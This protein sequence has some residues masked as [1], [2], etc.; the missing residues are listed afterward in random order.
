M[1]IQ[2]YVAFSLSFDSRVKLLDQAVT[3]GDAPPLKDRLGE[4]SAP[5]G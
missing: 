2:T 4:G 3:Y 5:V 1:S